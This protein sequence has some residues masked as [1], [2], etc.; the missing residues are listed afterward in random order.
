MDC[1]TCEHNRPGSPA[2][3]DR[4]MGANYPGEGAECGHREWKGGDHCPISATCCGCETE[5]HAADL[6]TYTKATSGDV[7]RFCTECEGAMLETMKK[8]RTGK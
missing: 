2:H 1:E 4:V 7:L 8:E 6:E 5:H 3:F